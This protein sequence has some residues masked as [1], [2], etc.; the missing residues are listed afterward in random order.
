MESSCAVNLHNAVTV[1]QQRHSAWGNVWPS[2]VPHERMRCVPLCASLWVAMQASDWERC[3]CPR[4]LRNVKVLAQV[5]Q[6]ATR[7]GTHSFFVF[8]AFSLFLFLSSLILGS[9]KLR[10]SG[11]GY[12]T[13]WQPHHRGVFCFSMVYCTKCFPLWSPTDTDFQ[14]L[15]FSPRSVRRT[16]GLVQVRWWEM[17]SFTP[18]DGTN[19][20]SRDSRRVKEI[21]RRRTCGIAAPGCRLV[22]G[23]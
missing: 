18:V 16:S 1:S 2:L 6:G 20:K 22:E 17:I 11:R 15:R 9:V 19:R 12:K 10:S 5:A 21:E 13:T 8:F 7:V 4:F 3:V 14:L 23:L